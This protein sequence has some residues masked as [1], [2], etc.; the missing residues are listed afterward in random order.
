MN[1]SQNIK[2]AREA[3]GLS[4]RQ[5]SLAAGLSQSAVAQIERQDIE[6]PRLETLERIAIAL[7]VSV[8][9]LIGGK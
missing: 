5:V 2:K 6:S 7:G 8:E 4:C 1:I 9:E 3:R